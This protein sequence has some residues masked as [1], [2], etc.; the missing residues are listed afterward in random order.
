MQYTGKKTTEISFPLGGIGS[1]CV[2]IGGDGRFK[3]WEIFNRPN[4]GSINHYSHFSIKAESD[5]R[6]LDCRCMHGDLQGS[7]MGPMTYFGEYRGFGHGPSCFTMAGL[8]HFK[9]CVFTG[10]FPF[11]FLDLSDENFPGQVRLTAFNPF[12]PLNEDDSSIPAAMFEVSVTN[13]SGAEIDYSIALSLKNP[14]KKIAINRYSE[15]DGIGRIFMFQK[16]YGEDEI[17][18]G[19][20]CIATDAED[21]SYQEA[22]Y[23]SGWRDD[24]ITFWRNFNDFGPL[25]PR[26]YA[27]DGKNGENG[28][29]HG[30]ISV[31]VHAKPGETKKARFVMS[32]SFPNCYN[33]MNPFKK[34]VNGVE[35]DVIWKNYYFKLFKDSRESADYA[36]KN[37]DRLYSESMR[38][39]EELFGQT[40]PGKTIEAISAGLCVLKSPT[41]LRLT[42]GEF[43]GY[44]GCQEHDGAC[45]GSCTHVWNYAYAMCFLFPRLERSIRDLD[46]KY[47]WREDGKMEFR[48]GL[49]LGRQ[50]EPFH[51]CVD[52]QMGGIFKTY[53]EWKISGDD[54][55]LKKNWEHVKSA[56]A[57][58]W[59]P[60]NPD[61]WDLNKDGVLEGR[62][63]NTLDTELFTASSW[64]EGYY[65]TALKA[66]AIM[67]DYLGEHEQANEYRKLYDNG[68]KYIEDNLF[69]GKYYFQKVDLTDR[70]LLDGFDETEELW[71]PETGEIK[72]QIGEGSEIDQIGAQWHADILG[73]GDI[74]DRDRVAVTLDSMYHNNFKKSMR[75]HYNPWRLFCI[76]DEAG[77]VICDYPEGSKK[78]SI[79]LS[80]AEETM[81]GF[82]YMLAAQMISR[83]MI[84]RG[85]ELI[86]GVRDKYDGEKRN[87]FNEIECGNNYA[88]SMA[89]F[90]FIP[91]FEGFKFDLVHGMIGFDPILKGDFKGLWSLDPAWGNVT[92]TDGAKMR[93]NI[94]KGELTLTEIGTPFDSVSDV[95][96]DGRKLAASEFTFEGKN[97]KLNAPTAVGS[98]IEV[99][100]EE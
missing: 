42:D 11:A 69:N 57:Y 51:A 84:D 37:F 56:L 4:K 74:F 62:Q 2:G 66:A 45:E 50:N 15:S 96:L 9:N 93:V 28:G 89:S 46:Y 54:E 91:L 78:P 86:A 33:H 27:D 6:V 75:N 71:N 32:W 53:R 63:H 23:R 34:T 55:W 29:D 61:K 87:P 8:P 73:L 83:G 12:I 24:F 44:E 5:G 38:F 85:L 26:S 52:G 35:K 77:T 14:H 30:T 7:F 65:I 88:R 80:Y 58:A 79:P 18:Y 20:L 10:E 81:H 1:G 31:K 97:V 99:I 41:C 60:T 21:Y 92:V 90:S 67:A 19:D 36:L 82:E 39:K 64:L 17:E 40:L 13:L 59:A 95:Y 68:K 48:M 25:S 94:I 16:E 3:D 47:N 72:Y 49:P 76:D 100:T 43:Y 70:S 22:W 98:T